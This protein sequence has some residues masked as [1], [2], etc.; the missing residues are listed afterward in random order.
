[1]TVAYQHNDSDMVRV[2]VKGAPEYIVPLCIQEMD[3]TNNVTDFNGRGHQ[4]E[5][6]LSDIVS[7]QIASTGQKPVTIAY[8]D[9]YLPDFKAL[10]SEHGNF[11]T[12]EGRTYLETELVLLT[13]IGL[14]DDIRPNAETVIS[15]L[16]DANTNT[17]ILSGDHKDTVIA[18]ARH[19][20]IIESDG[21]TGVISGE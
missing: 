8:R 13:T 18:I 19:F 2:I 10:Q 4:G 20:G 12:E 16:Y 11:E 7:R 14:I 3:A 15:N 17:R 1:M 6:H 9:I 5:E 21:E